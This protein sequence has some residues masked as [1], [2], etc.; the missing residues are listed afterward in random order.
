M[1]YCENQLN[2][3]YSKGIFI[4]PEGV[5]LHH[6]GEYSKESIINT[7]TNRDTAVSAHVVIWK[8]GSR[9]KFV[10]ENLKAWH[11]GESS[12][13]GRP[14]CNG[15]MLGVEFQGDTNKKPL[16]KQQIESFIEWFIPMQK[17]FMIKFANVTD[18]RTVSPGR[19]VDLNPKELTRIL[20]SLKKY[21]YG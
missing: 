1:K 8:D 18:H 7:F 11:A 12:F 10:E 5:V 13:N 17:K 15:F 21:I 19:K 2:G 9:T 3:N 14:G 20:E 4:K 6:T 16:T